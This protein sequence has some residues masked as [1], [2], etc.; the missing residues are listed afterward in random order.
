MSRVKAIK[1]LVIFVLKYTKA[2]YKGGTAEYLSSLLEM[3]GF[4]I[5]N[6]RP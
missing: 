2:S 6:F 1:R 3:R 5:E 4:F